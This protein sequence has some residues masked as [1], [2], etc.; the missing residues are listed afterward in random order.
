MRYLSCN[1]NIM[2]NVSRVSSKGIGH[3]VGH[4]TRYRFLV[5]SRKDSRFNEKREP[6][7]DDQLYEDDLEMWMNRLK[8]FP[9]P[10]ARSVALE[11]LI[12]VD[13]EGAYAGLVS[14]SPEGLV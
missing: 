14:G 5:Q 8:S 11:Q 10:S 4:T 2:M 13:E 7:Y 6:V 1:I 9:S 3:R 12:R